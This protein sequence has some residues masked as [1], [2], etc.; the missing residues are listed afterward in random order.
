LP[1]TGELAEV[2]AGRKTLILL[3]ITVDIDGKSVEP[4]GASLAD[5]N[6]G[7]AFVT[8]DSVRRLEFY[9]FPSDEARREGWIYLVEDPGSY[10]LAVQPPRTENAFSYQFKFR[11]APRW[12]IDALAG[13]RLV[14]GGR[15]RINGFTQ[16]GILFARHTLYDLSK[17]TVEDERGLARDLAVKFFPGL[18]PPITVV[19][20]PLSGPAS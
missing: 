20:Q 10:F 8:G 5:D 14:Y 17:T 4:F 16:A 13:A 1:T 3:R 12:R 11:F 2:S 18:G 7:L 9:R 15:L 19:M 6:V